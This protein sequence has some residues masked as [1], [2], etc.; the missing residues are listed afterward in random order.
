MARLWVRI[1]ARVI[2]W[3]MVV[4]Y[5]GAAITAAARGGTPAVIATLA[6]LALVGVGLLVLASV[7]GRAQRR[8]R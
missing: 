2:G 5:G 3:V 7:T 1:L 8:A 6:A 4:L